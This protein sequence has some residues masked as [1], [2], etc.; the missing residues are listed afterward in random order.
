MACS[1]RRRGFVDAHVPAPSR[2]PFILPPK[3]RPGNRIRPSFDLSILA[4]ESRAWTVEAD[5]I[6]AIRDGTSIELTTFETGVAYMEFTE[7]VARSA[8]LGEIIELPLA[9]FEARE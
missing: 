7:A 4:V 3:C 5:F 9:E 1:H 6:A 2:I 8:E